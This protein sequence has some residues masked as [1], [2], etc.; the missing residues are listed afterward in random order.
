M[1]DGAAERREGGGVDEAALSDL[2]RLE[3]AAS[4]APWVSWNEEDGGL[5]G[6]SFIQ[7]EEGDFPPDIYAYIRV[8]DGGWP[9]R[10]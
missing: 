3:R 1:T 7:P 9:H 8:A 10:A 4:A 2:E 6:E 5:G